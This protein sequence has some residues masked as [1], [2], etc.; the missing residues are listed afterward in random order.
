MRRARELVAAV[1]NK[2]IPVERLVI[3]RT[4]RPEG[5]YNEST[6]EGLPFLRVFKQLQ[7]EGY[8]RD[9]RNARCVGS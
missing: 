5:E 6:R 7:A 2:Q 3:A 8:E 9:P 1:Q 4:V